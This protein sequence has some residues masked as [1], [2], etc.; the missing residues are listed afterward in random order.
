MRYSPEWSLGVQEI[1]SG[2]HPKDRG[3]GWRKPKGI[4]SQSHAPLGCHHDI[5]GWLRCLSGDLG[6]EEEF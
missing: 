1:D 5:L 3:W 2:I 6:S 4:L